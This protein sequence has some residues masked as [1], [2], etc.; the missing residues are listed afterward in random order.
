MAEPQRR[1][2]VQ[3]NW[4]R[5]R[6]ATS[7]APAKEETKKAAP[8][9]VEMPDRKA[10][11]GFTFRAATKDGARVD[12]YVPLE[13]ETEARAA[14]NHAG[15]TV[16]LVKPRRAVRKKR[17]RI[18]KRIEL[19]QLAEQIGDLWEA[20]EPPT[21]I[22]TSLGVSSAN[23]LVATA[24]Q[25]AAQRVRNGATVSEALA[26]QTTVTAMPDPVK[27][28]AALAAGKIGKPVFPITLC[29]AVTIG[30]ESGAIE[31]PLTGESR[32]A[33]QWMMHQFAEAQ[34]RMDALWTSVKG[35]L[36]YPSAVLVVIIVVIF[37]MLYFALPQFKGM[38]EAMTNGGELPLPTRVLIAASDFATSTVGLILFFGLV[39]GA[40]SFGAWSRTPQGRDWVAEKSLWLP[41]FGEM[42]RE[43]N[44][45]TVARTLGM[46]ASGSGDISFA[47]RETARSITNPAYKRMIESVLFE[48]DRQ[49]RPLDVLFRPY[50]PLV[51]ES[52]HTVLVTYDK[53][54]SLDRHCARFAVVLE[55]RCERR[56]E[57]IKRA[58]NT[59][60]II[61]LAILAAGVLVAL[62]APLTDLVGKMAN[63]H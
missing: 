27:R 13:D 15:L 5:G 33:M 46:L 26:E 25:N 56:I 51:T 2:N 44:M 12:Y 61:P 11:N 59:Y 43:T 28:E 47:L 37:I 62:Y 4:R 6:A 63:A 52:F 9:A 49:A 24:L 58:L 31:D 10:K 30:E 42:M 1:I 22:L 32:G 48:F 40:A 57:S 14:L 8:A 55:N 39:L 41:I 16:E 54:G 60:M 35:A 38:Y 20:G 17:A 7:T 18:P 19:Q 21:T 50:T 29:H 36:V 45:A 53:S 23:P 34:A 3:S